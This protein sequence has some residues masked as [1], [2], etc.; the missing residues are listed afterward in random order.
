MTLVETQ[1]QQRPARPRTPRLYGLLAEYDTPEALLS[2]AAASREAGYTATDAF[3]PFPMETLG[4]TMGWKPSR[5]AA[6]FLVGGIVGAVLGF[7]HM[8][9]ANVVSYQIN[10]GGRPLNS[11]PAFLAITFEMTVLGSALTGFFA[12][13]LRCGLPRPHHPLFEVEGFERS[14]ID[15]FFLLIEGRDPKFDEHSTGEL[16]EGTQPLRVVAVEGGGP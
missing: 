11:W 3:S 16:L 12:L 4:E 6:A 13:F 1:P 9:Y 15:R 14:G 5:I 8:W 7:G 2:A 10:V